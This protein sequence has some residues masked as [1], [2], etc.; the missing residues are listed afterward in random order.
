MTLRPH[1][2]I[3]EGDGTLLP[4]VRRSIRGGKLRLPNGGVAKHEFTSFENFA[5]AVELAIIKFENGWGGNVTLN[6]SDGQSTSIRDAILHALKP[7]KIEFE[8]IPVPIAMAVGRLSQALAIGKTEPRISRYAVSQLAFARSYD[9]SDT[10]D[11]LGYEPKL[12]PA[13]S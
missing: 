13:F 8:S 6:V 5:N 11:L 1:A 7:E 4:R 10:I 3:G 9:L 2:L 12:A